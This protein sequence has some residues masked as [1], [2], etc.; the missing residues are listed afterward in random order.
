MEGTLCASNDR[1]FAPARRRFLCL[2]N[3]SISVLIVRS[4]EMVTTLSDTPHS[5][6]QIIDSLVIPPTSFPD[7]AEKFSLAIEL[8]GLDS[9]LGAFY[10]MPNTTLA[11]L[12]NTTH[13]ITIL[14]PN[15]AGMNTVTPTITS[16][17]NSSLT[18][19]LSYHIILSPNGPLFS[20][21]WTNGTTFTTLQ[22]GTVTLTL[23]SNSWFI[24]SARVL[25]QD[26][27]LANGVMHVLD[28]VLDPNVTSVQPI[29]QSAT[30][31]PVL[32][33]TTVAE[34]NSSMAPFTTFLPDAVRTAVVSTAAGHAG[35][36]SFTGASAV[37]SETGSV[38]S[39][40]GVA[41]S[42]KFVNGALVAVMFCGFGISVGALLL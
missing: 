38:S 30:Q 24:N 18:D 41:R 32:Q 23:A 20:T 27:L 39:S 37:P 33:T 14:A 10:S 1:N 15:N 31:A 26:L 2:V 9:F 28:N 4:V 11:T 3:M 36:S 21:N 12:L 5:I 34:F 29:P 42:T 35:L 6:I 22:G 8:Y 13:D 40:S 25:T 16:L 19:L 7:T 17:A